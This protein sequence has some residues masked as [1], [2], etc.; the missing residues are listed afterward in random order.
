MIYKKI[1]CANFEVH[2]RLAAVDGRLVPNH[3]DSAVFYHEA[4]TIRNRALAVWGQRVLCDVIGTNPLIEEAHTASMANVPL[5]HTI[6]T[7]SDANALMC[8]L[9]DKYDI[10]VVVYE[11]PSKSGRF[12]IRACMQIFLDELDVSRLAHAL[13][14]S[15][16][17]VSRTAQS[18]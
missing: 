6:R 7:S 4:L 2:F 18:S 13:I 10:D 9:R 3:H 14:D 8:R 11:Y 5:P 17:K 1:S 15:I 16:T 12:H